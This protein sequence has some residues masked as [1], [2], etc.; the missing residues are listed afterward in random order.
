MRNKT[1]SFAGKDI[2]VEEK[3]IGELHQVV[4]TLFPE[5]EGDI[6]KIDLDKIVERVGFDLLYDEIP[7]LIP[8][9]SRS[10]IENAYVSEV[11]DLIEAF[12]DVNFTGIKKL[13][14][15]LIAIMQAGMQPGSLRK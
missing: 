5:S 9:V 4:A 7:K 14:K 10:D 2:R 13:L 1:V 8:S 12:V 11:E 6:R 3:K 15:P